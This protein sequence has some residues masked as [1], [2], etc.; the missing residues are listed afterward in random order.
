MLWACE[1]IAAAMDASR[2]G[3]EEGEHSR[4]GQVEDQGRLGREDAVLPKVTR[5]RWESVNQESSE[6]NGCRWPREA[7]CWRG[8]V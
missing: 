8:V 5:P 6:Q 1:D 2:L 7:P 4:E 3:Q